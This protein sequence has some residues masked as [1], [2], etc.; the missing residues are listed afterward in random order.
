MDIFTNTK[1][2]SSVYGILITIGL[3]LTII[4]IFVYSFVLIIQSI[5]E[6]KQ[7]FLMS[8]L[9]LLGGIIILL[10]YLYYVLSFMGTCTTKPEQVINSEL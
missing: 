8:F 5:K 4:G 6:F 9:K 3:F 1:D 10:V 2:E 7:N